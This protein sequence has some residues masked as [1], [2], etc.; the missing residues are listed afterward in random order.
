MCRNS[1]VLK[2]KNPSEYLDAGQKARFQDTRPKSIDINRKWISGL[3]QLLLWSQNMH[4][5]LVQ[6]WSYHMQIST[7]YCIHDAVHYNRNDCQ[8]LPWSL[9]GKPRDA[10]RPRHVLEMALI[11]WSGHPVLIP[12]NDLNG[13]KQSDCH[14]TVPLAERVVTNRIYSHLHSQNFKREIS[15]MC[16]LK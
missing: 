9:A 3:C 6:V 7:S 13:R 1:I 5:S 10:T 2:L 12:V 15:H 16:C 14:A 8:T 4:T 11:D